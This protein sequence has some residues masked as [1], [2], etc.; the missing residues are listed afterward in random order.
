MALKMTAPGQWQVLA[1]YD[2][3]IGSINWSTISGTSGNNELLIQRQ[4]FGSSGK[5]D[6]GAGVRDQVNI[7]LVGAGY[8]NLIGVEF[9]NGFARSSASVYLINPAGNTLTTNGGIA[10][11]FGTVAADVITV[12]GNRG[13]IFQTAGARFSFQG[14]RSGAAINTIDL[15]GGN[16]RLILVNDIDRTGQDRYSGGIGANVLEIKNTTAGQLTVTFTSSDNDISNFQT[17]YINNAGLGDTD[18]NFSAQTEDLLIYDTLTTAV[19][20]FSGNDAIVGG[21]GNDTI[22]ARGGF[23][24]V[25]G[26]D[27]NDII[28]GGTGF[29]DIDGGLGNDT[30]YGNGGTYNGV[31]GDQGNRLTGGAGADRFLAGYIDG[32]TGATVPGGYTAIPTAQGTGYIQF[33]NSPAGTSW[34]GNAYGADVILDWT[35]GE[36]FLTVSAA[37]VGII[38]GLSIDASLSDANM[39]S[40]RSNVSN[41]GLIVARGKQNNDT[42][43]DSTG[44]DFLYGN[45]GNNQINLSAGGNDRAYV[46]T[47]S[48][49]QYINGFSSGDLV[50]LDMGVVNALGQNTARAG[51][52]NNASGSTHYGQQFSTGVDYLY[53]NYYFSRLS[54]FGSGPYTNA[55]HNSANDYGDAGKT[56]PIGA[57]MVAAG[58]ALLACTFGIVGASLVVAG[59]L[60]LVDA[61]QHQNITYS[62]SFNNNAYLNLMQQSRSV[63]ST[64]GVNDDSVAFLDFF[65]D[66][67]VVGDGFT[68]VLEL[69]NKS[70]AAGIYGFVAVHSD[71][72]TFIFLVRSADNL[73]ENHE[74]MKIA[75]INGILGTSDFRIYDGSKDIYNPGTDPVLALVEPTITAADAGAS[76]AG[77]DIANGGSTTADKATLTISLSP[78]IGT[79][80]TTIDLYD[81][82]TYV[83]SVSRSSTSTTTIT[84]TRTNS[85]SVEQVDRDG[86]GNLLPLSGDNLFRYDY[87]YAYYSVWVNDPA[88]GFV[89]K[90][91]VW[92]VTYKGIAP[93]TVINGYGGFDT[94]MIEETAEHLNTVSDANL[95]NIEMIDASGAE[96]GVTV[97][98]TAQ[99]EGFYVSGSDYD[100]I[101]TGGS[102][103]DTLVGNKGA[104]QLYG[105]NG[106]DIFVY[107]ALY[108]RNTV[109]S[110]GSTAG[111][112]VD[113]TAVQ[114]FTA[115]TVINGGGGTDILRFIDNVTLT[116]APF[117]DATS[118]EKL[119]LDDS[120]TLNSVTLGTNAQAAGL[121]YI[122][123]SNGADTINW[124]YNSLAVTIYGL[125]GDD[126]ID[127]DANDVVADTVD[128]GAGNDTIRVGGGS[129]VV[130]GG[131]GNDS[132]YGEGGD[133]TLTGG[134]GSDAMTGGTGNDTFVVDSGSDTIAD[135]G[136]G[137]DVIKVES[138]AT[139]TATAVGA[140][141]PSSSTYN[142]GTATITASGNNINLMSVSGDTGWTVTNASSS[143]GVNIIGSQFNDLITG[144]SGNDSL[145]GGAGADTLNGGLGADTLN[146]GAGVDYL[147]AGD[148]DDTLSGGASNDTM[149]GGIGVDTFNVDSG[150]DSITDLGQGGAD[151][152]KVETGATLNATAYA[153][154]TATSST[155]NKG[156]A[157]I[158]ASGKNINLSAVTGDTGW[159]VTNAGSS[160]AVTLTGSSYNDTLTGGSGADT[161]S[162]GSGNDTLTGG[163]GNDTLTGGAGNETF[164]VASGTDTITDLGRD[165]DI[166][167]ISAGATAN[168]TT[169]A[170]WT[171]T[172][173]TTNSG[174][175]NIS[176]AGYAVNLSAAGGTSG[177]TV[178]NTSATGTSLTGSANS[179]TLT[180]NSGAD[181]LTGGAGAD[182]ISGGLGDDSLRFTNSSELAGDTSVSGGSGTDTVY[183]TSADASVLDAE[184]ANVTGVE[185]LQLTGVS[186]VTL[187]ATATA[188]GINTVITGNDTTSV[189]RTDSTSTTI[190][191]N[192][193]ANDKVLTIDDSGVTTNFTVNNLT[194]DLVATDVLGT[195]NVDLNNNAGDNDIVIAIGQGNTTISGGDASDTVT[196]SQSMAADWVPVSST[197]DLSGS[198]SNV[199]IT[200][201]AGRQTIK[202]G[203]GVYYI[204]TGAGDG[205]GMDRVEFTVAGSATANISLTGTDADV[206]ARISSFHDYNEDVIDFIGSDTIGSNISTGSGLATNA[207]GVITSFGTGASTTLA[208]KIATV[209]SALDGQ[210]DAATNKVVIFTHTSGGQ[211]DTYAY[212]LGTSAL[213]DDQIV[214]IANDSLNTIT[215]GS[216]FSLTVA[217]PS[218]AVTT[219]TSL[220]PNDSTWYDSAATSVDPTG[221]TPGNDGA[222]SGGDGVN[223]ATSQLIRNSSGNF[224]TQM[225]S[226]DDYSVAVTV[227][228][229]LWSNGLDMFG[230]N[231]TTLYMGSNGYVTFGSGYSGYIPSGIDTFT[232]SPMIAG[233]FDDLY[234]GAGTR[235]ISDG[236]GAGTSLNTHNMYYYSTS[237]MLV[238]TWDNVGLYSN[239]VSDS[240]TNAGGKGSAFQIILHKLDGE[241][242]A[243]TSFGM[244]IRYE[245]ISQQYA[246]ATA[247]WTAGDRVNFGLINPSK[248][249][250]YSIAGSSSNVG[251]AGVWAWQVEG[252]AIVS[253]AF[254][255]DVGLTSTKDTAAITVRGI[256]ADPTRY[257]LGGEAAGQFTI[258]STGTNTAKITTIYGAT[259]NLW[260]DAYVDMEATV[261][262]TPRA[263]DGTSGATDT[264]NVQLTRNLDNDSLPGLA[265]KAVR[266]AGSSTITVAAGGSLVDAA[267]SDLGQTV[268]VG[269]STFN[270]ITT[271]SATGSGS[272]INV[273]HQSEGFNL[274][275]NSGVDTITGGS[276]DDTITGAA[277]AD[278]LSGGS[279]NDTIDGGSGADTMTGADG[280]DVFIIAAASDHASGE[281]ISGGAQTGADVIRFTSTAAQTLVLRTGV[282]GIE[283]VRITDASGL[284][285]G[286][287]A[288][289]VDVSQLSVAIDVYGNDGNNTL[290]G[291]A[292]ANRI[293]GGAGNDVIYGGEGADVL[294]GGAGADAIYLGASDA[295]VDT[296]VLGTGDALTG[297][298]RDGVSNE[299]ANIDVIRNYEAGSDKIDLS[300]IANLSL[301]DITSDTPVYS[302]TTYHDGTANSVVIVQGTYDAASGKFTAGLGGTN[303]DYLLQYTGTGPS[304]TI[305][306]VLVEDFS[307]LGMTLTSSGE[308][309]TL[310]VGSLDTS[311]PTIVSAVYYNSTNSANSYELWI[312]FSEG[313]ESGQAA[314]DETKLRWDFNGDTALATTDGYFAGNQITGQ[315]SGTPSV[316]RFVF[317]T[318]QIGAAAW[319]GG[320]F[321]SG[322]LSSAGFGGAIYDTIDALAGLT[323]DFAGN[324]LEPTDDVMI[325]YNWEGTAAADVIYGGGAQDWLYGLGGND[326]IYGGDGADTVSGGDGDD[327]IRGGRGA[328]TMAGGAG[329]DTYHF[330]STWSGASDSDANGIDTISDFVSG[331]DKVILEIFDVSSFDA[332]SSSDLSTDSVGG[333]YIV[334]N[335]GSGIG[336]NPFKLGIGNSTVSLLDDVRFYLNGTSSADTFKGGNSDDFFRGIGGNDTITGGSGADTF[337]FEG[338]G[339]ANGVDTID[340]NLAQG[341]R[342]NL[343][344]FLPGGSASTAFLANQSGSTTANVTGQVALLLSTTVNGV[345]DVDTADEVAA[346]FTTTYGAGNV[347]LTLNNGG[348]AVIITG[349]DTSAQNAYIWFVNDA[350][351][352]G[353][354]DVAEVTQVGFISS[355]QFSNTGLSS[356]NFVFG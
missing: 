147:D 145:T 332:T 114:A 112:T 128:G 292:S 310:D 249:N 277:D 233:Q 325:Q 109:S 6:L 102:G 245:E 51:T 162:G 315:S 96:Q 67:G 203:T 235:N 251:V 354:V 338:S 31:T 209:R 159:T 196:V 258:S 149:V 232:R 57:G 182:T 18:A 50:Y 106:N 333:N 95:L 97:T 212:G 352:N 172:A 336:T 308:V 350:D 146:G 247:G 10:N 174:T 238:F 86:S 230:T 61:Q 21:R 72:E 158:T 270:R 191:A 135:L 8:Y 256:T 45:S 220:L 242:A 205:T 261:T 318:G 46:D 9:L 5:I 339:I 1:E 82:S 24:D 62:G 99:S 239:G 345:A 327:W 14:T 20:D 224:G 124:D 66:R 34:W 260:K 103:A 255:P 200:L 76:T 4:Y 41:N 314:V 313:V 193:L 136:D 22:Y 225:G 130:T 324:A 88:T 183:L 195:L 226:G 142:K 90:S 91:G 189:T 32:V 58:A 216:S 7:D 126:V 303:N 87:T 71:E 337:Y 309:L 229:S 164:V 340:F 218:S 296:V 307:A 187:G 42:L 153:D 215:V 297:T 44:V 101:I 143:T 223:G 110:S 335:N 180:G 3:A 47:M 43:L 322:G 210:G 80:A 52:I 186:S 37:G 27:G 54:N 141:A 319:E 272:T 326:R 30:L 356:S 75:E 177:W 160:T 129:D 151:I 163:L 59:G 217:P 39:I 73:I 38:G 132:I 330:S 157:T 236:A 321:S 148:G 104:D 192:S 228:N 144:G 77:A 127:N 213:N 175:G 12:T 286:T 298:I 15:G 111:A 198:A 241:T 202:A 78:A 49:K 176:T 304:P 299:V 282:T 254:L 13:A 40:L 69:T 2:G 190:D 269:A 276:G 283:E 285:T 140:W 115:D 280:D 17:V 197:I 74:A 70:G 250:L 278:V 343:S 55:Q 267:D 295:A 150:T 201:D 281:T 257:L 178:T 293:S 68:P 274:N 118:V 25:S 312:T 28:Y 331:S 161:L 204:L 83:T 92:A 53:A 60:L 264:I 214:R 259:F 351:N 302:G 16:D 300:G 271:I 305:N 116:D 349:E 246:G 348:K 19:S 134:A 275:G 234:T 248:T 188:A 342:L 207:T 81:G 119:D 353:V 268:T 120:S 123:A 155:Y 265:D 139:M 154:W 311:A 156:T 33:G 125:G 181:T 23:D 320:T 287:T 273:S 252:G 63:N 323:S 284:A 289:S 64:A 208:E 301:A 29:D 107:S 79:T 85:A 262:V 341:D 306:S 184:F 100:D 179:D 165:S 263:S 206:M 93:S 108:D 171:A 89:T 170:G 211:T 317:N 334:A 167:Q 117:A 290:T 121:Y 253:N 94:L 294:T 152:V 36:D 98:L 56:T 328:D 344:A 131:D 316:L 194:G 221:F 48:G 244:E 185:Q 346:A 84:D 355:I 231:Y 173:S 329:A 279:G 137:D 199:N 288:E 122:D 105:G 133:D 166:L 266:T 65:L 219:H 138:G 113:F 291:N 169:Y 35:A 26:H 222:A 237:D 168:A 11:L 243:S 347:V 227:P 240:Q